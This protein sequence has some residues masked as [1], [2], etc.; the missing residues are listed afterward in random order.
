M[1]KLHSAGSRKKLVKSIVV[2]RKGEQKLEK[3]DIK[4]GAIY[5]L[6]GPLATVG[7]D[8]RQAIDLA[9]DIVNKRFD[10][11]LPLARSKGFPLL[12]SRKIKVIY[13]DSQGNPAIGRE[14]ARRLIETENVIAL[15]GSYQSS[16]TLQ[17]STV[18]E[19]KKVP[20]LTP[21]ASAPSLT[22]RGFSWFFRS[23]PSDR[24]YTKPATLGN[25]LRLSSFSRLFQAM[26]VTSLG[27]WVGFVA[28][29]ALVTRLGG[30]RAGYA[31]S[32]VMLARLLPALLFGPFAGVLVDRFD[33]KRLM[34]IADI[35]RGAMYA[36][37][38]RMGLTPASRATALRSS[39]Y[40]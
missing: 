13:G 30:G 28:V 22:E 8:I 37:M 17:A 19:A 14:E 15:I 12:G 33:R 11:P 1:Q 35:G 20:F 18:A 34:I 25:L 21:E 23:A 2:T 36:S 5:P 40:E 24:L 16:V 31:V 38:P 29:V 4:I 39:S 32:G 6:T 10:L 27:D 3:K 26:A 9:V 7:R